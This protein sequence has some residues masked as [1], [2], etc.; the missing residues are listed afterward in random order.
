[1]FKARMT[2]RLIGAPEQ[3]DGGRLVLKLCVVY[4]YKKSGERSTRVY[5]LNVRGEDADRLKS[6]TAGSYVQQIGEMSSARKK[7][8]DCDRVRYLSDW[9]F[10]DVHLLIDVGEKLK[11][12][13]P[14]DAELAEKRGAFNDSRPSQRESTPANTNSGWG[15][16]AEDTW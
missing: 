2:G 4:I 14:T 12:E 6:A 7:D 15:G 3:K 13:C 16:D 5:T 10:P 1:M 9:S 11:G 8:G